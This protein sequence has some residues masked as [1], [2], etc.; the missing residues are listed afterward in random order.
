[1]RRFNGPMLESMM[2]TLR[3]PEDQ[4]IES[5]MVTRAIRSAQTQVEQQNFEVRKDVLKYDEVLNRQRTVIYDERRKILEGVDLADQVQSMIDDVVT[6]YVTGATETG[7][8]EDWD[9]EQLWTGL[10]ALYPVG[11]DRREFLDRIADGD[12]A[13]L[14]AED[15][16]KELLR[17]VHRAYG[18]RE[19][20]LGDEVM[21][22]LERRGVLAGAAPQGGGG[23]PRKGHPPAR[24]PPP[25]PGH[26]PPRR[27]GPRA[28]RAKVK[29]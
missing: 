6:A 16:K 26:P 21:R 3:V 2:N 28:G 17:D 14:S 15:L 20:K 22:E 24:L 8:A 11:L 9:L 5:K 18:E 13:A 27:G 25:A 1:M 19:A 4:P 29:T 23:P 7:Y 12:Q 10:K